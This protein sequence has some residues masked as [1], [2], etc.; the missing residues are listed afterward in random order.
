[1]AC[2]TSQSNIRWKSVG[3]RD[4]GSPLAVLVENPES[5][6][7]LETGKTLKIIVFIGIPGMF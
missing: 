6:N 2:G 7:G 1:M 5:N 4:N 3:C